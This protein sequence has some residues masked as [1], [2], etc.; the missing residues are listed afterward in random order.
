M[1]RPSRQGTPSSQHLQG[2]VAAQ[3]ASPH[4]HSAWTALCWGETKHKGKVTPKC[5]PHRLLQPSP[6]GLTHITLPEMT[7]ARKD[8]GIPE[9]EGKCSLKAIKK[10]KS[11]HLVS[12]AHKRIWDA[13]ST[14]T[15]IAF[16]NWNAYIC[17]GA[18]IAHPGLWGRILPEAL[19]SKAACLFLRGETDLYGQPTFCKVLATTLMRFTKCWFDNESSSAPD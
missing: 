5:C 8:E 15:L 10:G 2:W 13:V 3:E 4:A 11:L 9:E 16:S 12:N 17:Q 19:T 18:N 1:Y 14:I 7:T 6:F